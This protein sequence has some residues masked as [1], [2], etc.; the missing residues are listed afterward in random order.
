MVVLDNCRAGAAPVISTVE[1]TDPT[2]RLT[3]WFVVRA[4]FTTI[5]V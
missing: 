4:A 1:L 5:S 2:F 3:G